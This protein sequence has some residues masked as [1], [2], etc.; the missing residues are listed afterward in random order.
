MSSATVMFFQ[1]LISLSRCLYSAIAKITSNTIKSTV[2]IEKEG[3]SI[4]LPILWMRTI[5]STVMIPPEIPYF[6]P[7][8]RICLSEV[9][10]LL[11]FSSFCFIHPC[12]RD[13]SKSLFSESSQLLVF[14]IIT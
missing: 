1:N 7:V 14:D 4:L 3:S 9:F 10:I 11:S 13:F 5:K 8:R 12:G 6:S 2:I